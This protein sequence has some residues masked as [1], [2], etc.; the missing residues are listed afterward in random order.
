VLK[1]SKRRHAIG[2]TIGRIQSTPGPDDVELTRAT[3]R[4][5]GLDITIL[6][7]HSPHDGTE[8]IS[9][10][11]RALP[12]LAALS[13]AMGSLHPLTFWLEASRLAWIPWLA[14]T[15]MM[16][17]GSRSSPMARAQARPAGKK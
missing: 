1:L 4:L 16:L 3:A 14:A 17:G 10:N 2:G 9:I 12:S 15:Q 5:L 7:R 6:R 13:R 11:L 8:E